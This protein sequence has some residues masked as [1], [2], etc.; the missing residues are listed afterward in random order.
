MIEVQAAKNF[1]DWLQRNPHNQLDVIT[2]SH[3]GNV[4]FFAT[5]L[6]VKVRKRITLGTPIRLEYSPD[7]R[8]VAELHNVFQPTITFKSLQELYRTA[9]QTVALLATR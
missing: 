9:G 4:C 8:N 3:G 1:R 5:R 6:G 7:L 2:H